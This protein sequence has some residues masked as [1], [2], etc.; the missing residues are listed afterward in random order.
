MINHRQCLINNKSN[1]NFISE[2]FCFLMKISLLLLISIFSFKNLLYYL[3]NWNGLFNNQINDKIYFLGENTHYILCILSAIISLNLKTLIIYVFF[4][5]NLWILTFIQI[6]KSYI[7]SLEFFN[8]IIL[9]F[10]SVSLNFYL[11]NHFLVTNGIITSSTSKEID[12][13]IKLMKNVSQE[14]KIKLDLIKMQINNLIISSGYKKCLSFLLF[15]LE[16]YS[17]FNEAEINM[18]MEE[19]N[20]LFEEKH[21]GNFTIDKSCSTECSS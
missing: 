14:I 2:K 13:S 4:L 9:L 6:N 11:I 5:I 3:F 18:S 17:F 7:N 10:M 21:S 15:K 8:L 12:N 19:N 16:D 1:L 20:T